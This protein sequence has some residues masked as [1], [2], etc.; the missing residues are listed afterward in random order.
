MNGR[1]LKARFFVEGLIAEFV[2]VVN[3]IE[4]QQ[5]FKFDGGENILSL[6]AERVSVDEKQNSTEPLRLQEMIN[7]AEDS[8]RLSGA[9][10]H[11][12]QNIFFARQE[13]PFRQLGRLLSDSRADLSHLRRLESQAVTLAV[14]RCPPIYRVQGVR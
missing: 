6:F 11:C 10:R 9:R 3:F 1:D 7:Y 5:V 14:S 12:N 2:D 13:Q 8:T 4:R